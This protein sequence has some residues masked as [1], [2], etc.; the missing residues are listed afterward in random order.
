[1][2]RAPLTTESWIQQSSRLPSGEIDDELM[3]LDTSRGEVLG[4][5]RIG[6]EI[7]RLAKQPAQVA[8]VLDWIVDQYDVAREAAWKDIEP[9]LCELIEAG[10]IELAE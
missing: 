3:A 9:F 4:L 10:L 6:T 2:S 5:D 7:W 8:T 1:M